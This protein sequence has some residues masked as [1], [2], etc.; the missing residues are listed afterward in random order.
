MTYNSFYGFDGELQSEAWHIH[1]FEIQPK[2]GGR[3]GWFADYAKDNP[4]APFQVLQPRR[5]A[6]G[7]SGR[8][9]RVVAER[10]RVPSQ[11]RA[12]A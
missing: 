6:R 3:F 2:Q 10:V 7:D 9:V 1:A 5:P 4:T 8:A 11:S 12:R